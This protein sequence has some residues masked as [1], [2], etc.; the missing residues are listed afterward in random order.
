MNRL[1]DA[2]LDLFSQFASN[3]GDVALYFNFSSFRP[4]F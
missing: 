3:I 4:A 2:P 1:I